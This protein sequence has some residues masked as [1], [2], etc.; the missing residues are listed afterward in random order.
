MN[1]WVKRVIQDKRYGFV[2]G[3]ERKEYFF[4]MEDF[5]GSWEELVKDVN[6]SDRVLVEFEAGNTARGLR[7]RN[8]VRV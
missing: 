8:V 6:N 4:H 2:V 5:M 3:D 7:A 1:G